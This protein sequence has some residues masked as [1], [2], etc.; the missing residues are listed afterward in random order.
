MFFTHVPLRH[1]VLPEA[2]ETGSELVG[3]DFVLASFLKGD[4]SLHKVAQAGV[5]Y[6]KLTDPSGSWSNFDV[7]QLF[8][9]AGSSWSHVPAKSKSFRA[10]LLGSGFCDPAVVFT[11]CRPDNS[12]RVV[13]LGSIKSISALKM[14]AAPLAILKRLGVIDQVVPYSNFYYKVR[15]SQGVTD[16]VFQS[17]VTSYNRSLGDVLFHS[18][19]DGDVSFD[20]NY[21]DRRFDST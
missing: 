9:P 20:L 11:P 5:S 10:E 13:K 2:K 21:A 1:Y 19:T 8:P 3:E 12:L 16:E 17:K 6:F 14:R 18:F 4:E 15:L 7:C